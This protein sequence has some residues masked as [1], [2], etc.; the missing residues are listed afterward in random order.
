[1]AVMIVNVAK[2]T[3]SNSNKNFVDKKDISDWV[4]NSVNTAEAHGIISGYPDN[5]FKPKINAT[6]AEAVTIL[7]KVL[8]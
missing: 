6:R 4:Q 5:T 2:L 1:M 3:P 8:K 7:I